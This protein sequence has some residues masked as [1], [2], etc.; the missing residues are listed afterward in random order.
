MHLQGKV[1]CARGL[2]L[3][4]NAPLPPSMKTLRPY[5]RQCLERLRQRYREGK[6]RLLVSLPTGT[7]KTIIFAQFPNYFRMKKRLLVLAHREELLEQALEKFHD[8]DPNLPVEIEQAGKRA[9]P[10]CK[11]MVASVPTIGRA[12]NKRLAALDPEDFSLIVVQDFFEEL[13]AK[14]GR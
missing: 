11:V 9:S 5:Q 4:E 13:R 3:N 2:T 12:G 1:R 14:A 8:V 7:G 10:D 6:R